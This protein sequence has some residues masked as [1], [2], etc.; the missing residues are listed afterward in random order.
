MP[1]PHK[2][3]SPFHPEDLLEAARGRTQAQTRITSHA[4]KKKKDD[5]NFSI[6]ARTN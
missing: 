6:R 1:T 5:R 2:S 4:F 3:I